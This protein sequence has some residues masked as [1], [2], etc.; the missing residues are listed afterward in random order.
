MDRGTLIGLLLGFGLLVLAMYMG[1]RPSDFVYPESMV[2]VFGGIIASTLIR[3]PL[4]TVRSAFDVA[5]RA[6]FTHPASSQQLVNE[7]VGLS[8]RARREG[9]L[10][11]EKHLPSDPFMEQGIRMVVDRVNRD[12]IHDVL[13]QEIYATQERHALG[14]ETFRFIATAAPSF[15]MVGTLIGMVHLFTSLKDPSG[16]GHGMAL[17]LLSTLYGAVIAYLFALPIS[18][19]LELRSREEAATKRLMLEGILGIA[20]EMNP[21]QLEDALNA[22]LAPRYKTRRAGASRG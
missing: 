7:L 3:F 5:S 14:Q 22:S 19:K 6:F 18:G 9:I 8:Q 11:L 21:S 10:G 12:H 4:G 2:V 16:I 1:G 17:S 15:G 20:D 13:N